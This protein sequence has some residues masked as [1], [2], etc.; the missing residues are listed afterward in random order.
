MRSCE[1]EIDQR[2]DRQ[3]LFDR[4]QASLHQ[5]QERGA[6]VPQIRRDL[7]A[8]HRRSTS[9]RRASGLETLVPRTEEARHAAQSVVHYRGRRRSWHRRAKHHDQSSGRARDDHRL[10]HAGRRV[11]RPHRDPRLPR[12]SLQLDGRWHA[13]Q[14]SGSYPSRGDG[15]RAPH[16]RWA[17]LL[18]CR[19]TRGGK[20]RNFMFTVRMSTMS[21]RIGKHGFNGEACSREQ[22]GI[23]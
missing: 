8:V 20:S 4:G 22:P 12:S 16:S 3:Q 15:P 1:T 13:N 17:R 10:A 14:Q 2:G 18:A 7:P 23:G 11:Q 21:P 5:G 9:R 19:S 6:R